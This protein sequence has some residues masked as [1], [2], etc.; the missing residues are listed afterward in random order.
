[1]SAMAESSV[2]AV[3]GAD[4]RDCADAADDEIETPSSRASPFSKRVM[5]S[6]VLKSNATG[7]H[8]ATAV[9]GADSAPTR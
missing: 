7:S 4:T 8:F 3:D 1:M 5:S 9:D 2:V 6:F